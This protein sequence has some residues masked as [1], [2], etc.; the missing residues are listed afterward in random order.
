MR[1]PLKLGNDERQSSH[2]AAAH[3][4][5]QDIAAARKGDWQARENV[6]RGFLPL[7]TSMAEKRTA[8]P[9][10]RT[11]CIEAAREGLVKAM[12]KYRPGSAR[13]FQLFAVEFIEAAMDRAQ[14][15]GGFLGRLFGG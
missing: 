11:Q 9:E 10:A 3:A 7:I 5:E 4:L 8:E 6:L 1:I 12:N 15:G 14:K 13:G 2:A